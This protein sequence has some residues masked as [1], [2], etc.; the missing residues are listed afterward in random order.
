LFPSSNTAVFVIF[1]TMFC[2]LNLHYTYTK[3]VAQGTNTET[4]STDAYSVGNTNQL[5]ENAQHA[6]QCMLPQQ[7]VCEE[8]RA[9]AEQKLRKTL[10]MPVHVM[11]HLVLCYPRKLCKRVLHQ[12]YS[13]AAYSLLSTCKESCC[14]AAPK[15]LS[16]KGWTQ[17]L[18]HSKTAAIMSSDFG[19]V[20]THTQA[21]LLLCKAKQQQAGCQ[22]QGGMQ[23]CTTCFIHM[24]RPHNKCWPNKA[25]VLCSQGCI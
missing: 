7:C 11:F 17:N 8:L 2:C 20:C 13:G 19:H 9:R 6:M 21:V 15:A 3:T 22:N 12:R 24:Y 5:S 10:G 1:P 14:Q 25:A 4:F 18:K 23:V 16:N